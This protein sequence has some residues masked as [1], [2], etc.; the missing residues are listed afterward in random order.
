MPG[1][2]NSKQHPQEQVRENFEDSDSSRHRGLPTRK[3]QLE[4][5]HGPTRQ[6]RSEVSDEDGGD[7]ESTEDTECDEEEEQPVLD[8]A[9]TASGEDGSST[10][11]LTDQGTASVGG[12]SNK[13]GTSTIRAATTTTSLRL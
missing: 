11:F 8:C 6:R 2:L 5:A 9:A 12:D 10:F 3:R 1:S 4:C 13:R 7:S